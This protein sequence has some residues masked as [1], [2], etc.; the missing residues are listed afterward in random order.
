MSQPPAG[1]LALATG[2]LAFCHFQYA[3]QDLTP[4][5]SSDTI[6][7]HCKPLPSLPVARLTHWKGACSQEAV[8]GGLLSGVLVR[9][10]EQACNALVS[11]VVWPADRLAKELAAARQEVQQLTAQVCCTAGAW[12]SST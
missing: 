12:R 5:P 6:Q 4:H 10:R 9:L 1:L 3:S 11:E 8:Q 7:P 2:L